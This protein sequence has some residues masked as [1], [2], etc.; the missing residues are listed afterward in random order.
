[1][2]IVEIGVCWGL[3]S[4]MNC[5]SI[6]IGVVAGLLYE[7]AYCDDAVSVIGH[8]VYTLGPL[9]FPRHH[10]HCLENLI[11]YIFQIY[12]IYICTMRQIYISVVSWLSEAS[13]SVYW[14][15]QRCTCTDRTCAQLVI[16]A[17]AIIQKF[18]SPQVPRNLAKLPVCHLNKYAIIC[19]N[20]LFTWVTHSTSQ[21][22]SK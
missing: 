11:Q 16:C 8:I 17:R 22:R 14:A 18:A 19:N 6:C 1:M 13:L 20:N 5:R 12:L 7:L 2:W 3:G 21:E 10:S 4:R 9:Q 15:I